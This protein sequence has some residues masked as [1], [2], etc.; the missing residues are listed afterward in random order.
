[1]DTKTSAFT[2]ATTKHEEKVKIVIILLVSM[3]MSIKLLR[4]FRI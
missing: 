3:K 1:M 4:S 2:L